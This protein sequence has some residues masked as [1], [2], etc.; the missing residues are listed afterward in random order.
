MRP[1]L[2][3]VASATVVGMLIAGC[4]GGGRDNHDYARNCGMAMDDLGLCRGYNSP[5]EF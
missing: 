3:L 4:A 5:H 2:A 1:I